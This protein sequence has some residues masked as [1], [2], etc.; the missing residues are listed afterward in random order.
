MDSLTISA[1]LYETGKENPV[2]VLCHQANYNK[3][4]YAGI[5]EVLNEKGFNC[6]AI[7]Q[8]YGG[9][10]ANQQNETAL[11]ASKKRAPN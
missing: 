3:F 9:P 4:E 6:L 1:N 10:I 11:E 8:R 5:A 7:D 2:I